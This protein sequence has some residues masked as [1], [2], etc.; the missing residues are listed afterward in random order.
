[1]SINALTNAAIARRLDFV[2][3]DT[4]PKFLDQ[5]AIAAGAVPRSREQVTANKEGNGVNTALN[6]LFGYI[7]VEVL[8]LYV[9]IL[10]AL[11]KPGQITK[12]D[13]IAFCG[14]LVATPGITWLVYAAKL[15]NAEKPIPWG[16]EKWP[17]WEMFAATLAYSAWAFALP[18]SPFTHYDWYSSGLAGICLLVTS[19]ILGLLAPFFQKPL[20]T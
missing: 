10:A 3:L 14:F 6:V 2:P 20:A 1:M 15:K 5:I 9:A 16:F 7:P 17:V 12:A 13:W 18:N 4:Q 11:Q 8:T 19:T